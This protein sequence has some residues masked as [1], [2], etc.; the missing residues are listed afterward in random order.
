MG[1]A[2][3]ISPAH[4]ERST[5]PCIDCGKCNKVCPSLLPVDQLVT[6]RSAECTA[7][8]ECVAICPAEG[9]L[10]FTLPRKRTIAPWAV[11]A[12]IA[13]FFL[14][15]VVYARLSGHWNPS[16]SEQTYMEM[17]RHSDLAIHP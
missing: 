10:A 16:I 15:T 5:E 12:A 11:A 9:A 17:V 1:I 8:M 13:F 7:C 14:G 3:L 4:I 6:I 2:A